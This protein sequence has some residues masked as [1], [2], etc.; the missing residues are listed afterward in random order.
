[1]LKILSD[2]YKAVIYV[3]I[4]VLC[5][6]LHDLLSKK[7][8]QNYTIFMILWFRYLFHFSYALITGKGVIKES[9]FK[10]IHFFRAILMTSIGL[11]FITGL[12]YL[13]LSEATA[14][15]FLAPSLVLLLS[16]VFLKEKIT[17][18]EILK[19]AIGFLGILLIARPGGD[20]FKF[21]IIFP[22]LAALFFAVYQI[23]TKIVGNSENALISNYYLG[24]YAL[25]LSSTFLPL[26]FSTI[27]P[28]DLLFFFLVGAFGTF[29]HTLFNKAYILE[30]P[31]KLS[32][33]SYFQILFAT[34]WGVTFF[35]S[36]PD[37]YAS[38][39]ILIIISSGINIHL[40]KNEH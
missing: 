28:I 39:G 40:R 5:L 20:I 34:V 16:F 10:K 14:I 35:N 29:A 30:S 19:V 3:I 8:N 21:E 12:K 7:L 36:I 2:H 11:S 23:L 13:P 4:A 22:M 9:R 38:I 37:I 18:T 17:S 33:Y 27:D 32:P 1:M 25:I 26:S 24:L 31:A 15:N 6:S